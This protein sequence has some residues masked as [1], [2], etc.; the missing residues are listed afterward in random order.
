MTVEGPPD[1]TT[2]LT[3]AN[4]LTILD[5]SPEL[6][7]STVNDVINYTIEISDS[8]LFTNILETEEVGVSSYSVSSVLE[9]GTYY[10]RV[11]TTNECGSSVSAAFSFVVS[12]SNT[13][14]LNG[15]Q[16]DFLPNPTNDLVNV[17]FS[18]AIP[19]ELVVEVF[20]VNGQ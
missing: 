12:T 18:E 10:W 2:L 16:V 5:Q 7:W 19:G 13:R 4:G 11:T 8:D 14:E 9:A 20:S 6:D 3:P 17:L 1:F 15:R